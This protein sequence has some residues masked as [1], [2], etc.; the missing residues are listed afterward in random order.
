MRPLHAGL[1]VALLA[2]GCD[3]AMLE[4]LA[5]PPGM[6]VLPSQ[7]PGK[8]TTAAAAAVGER[9][10]PLD[11]SAETWVADQP[12]TYVVAGD[13]LTV[14]ERKGSALLFYRPALGDTF[15]LRFREPRTTVNGDLTIWWM[16]DRHDFP[17]KDADGKA[18]PGGEHKL[19]L[20]AGGGIKLTAGGR[21]QA[22]RKAAPG[23]RDWLIAVT[24]GH[25]TVTLNGETLADYDHVA[26]YHPSPFLAFST[27]VTRPG[28][29]ALEQVRVESAA[30]GARTT[31]IRQYALAGRGAGVD[32]FN[33]IYASDWPKLP[34]PEQMDGLPA[35]LPHVSAVGGYPLSRLEALAY[36]R[37][38]GFG[39][40]THGGSG[41]FVSPGWL[42][43]NTLTAH[44]M[45]HGYGQGGSKLARSPEGWLVEGLASYLGNAAHYRYTGQPAWRVQPIG[46]LKAFD[47]P[48]TMPR[49]QMVSAG[50]KEAVDWT[51]YTKGRIFLAVLAAHTSAEDVRA[52]IGANREVPKVTG[53]RFVAALEA[54]TGKDLAFLRPGWLV[55]GA[56]QGPTPAQANDTD[57]D[58]LL[59][60]QELA[61]GSRPETADTDGDGASDFAERLA[62]TDATL[63]TSRPSPIAGSGFVGGF[64]GAAIEQEAPTEVPEE[65]EAPPRDAE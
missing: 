9:L 30:P 4:L 60:F 63:A 26:G 27:T 3:A 24:A 47:L 16:L 23:P 58:G 38:D 57:K 37:T 25:T 39:G 54:R 48:L 36:A 20:A 46:K 42:H 2:S 12:E 59:D 11:L 64:L 61:W 21:V 65:P 19:L 8:A 53:E 22:E 43:A 6:P 5:A 1:F 10:T 32:R 55:G 45:A 62:G 41:I 49:D 31:L 50:G 17:K 35:V 13:R 34:T 44:E 14:P 29:M 56:Y 18:V 52:V 40:G 28:E 33:V 15:S 7:A 51:A